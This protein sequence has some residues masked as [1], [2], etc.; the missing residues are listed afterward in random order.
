MILCPP[1]TTISLETIDILQNINSQNIP[2]RKWNPSALVMHFN[3]VQSRLPWSHEDHWHRKTSLRPS[4][5]HPSSPS[6]AQTGLCI[7]LSLPAKAGVGLHSQ[8]THLLAL[9]VLGSQVWL[10][11]G[12]SSPQH[13][14]HYSPNLRK[15]Q[16]MIKGQ[17][18]DSNS[19]CPACNAV[20]T[21]QKPYREGSLDPHFAEGK[22]KVQTTCKNLLEVTWLTEWIPAKP[23]LGNQL[24]C[25]S[26]DLVS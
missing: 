25:L 8:S 21:P 19:T 10:Q 13:L 4:A 23:M 15:G 2:V 14:L 22:I 16:S 11:K 18:T 3:Q 7:L 17:N 9:K 20:H 5:A 12:L 1:L 6:Q 24:P 26:A